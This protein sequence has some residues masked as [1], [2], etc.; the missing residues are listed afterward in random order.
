M[1]GCQFHCPGCFNSEAWD[2]KAGKPF[3]KKAYL[4][5]KEYLS[6]PNIS[7][8]SILGGDPL[9][10][11]DNGIMNLVMLCSYVHEIG[12]TVWIWSGFTW[13]EIFKEDTNNTRAMRAMLIGNCDVWVDG[14]FDESKKDLRLKWR[15][16][17]NQ[18]VIDVKKS[19]KEKKIVL[20]EE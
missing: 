6:D 10:Q 11:D 12:K 5:I 15:G 3:G 2:Y 14:L 7:G 18:R 1:S 8:L 4:R 13:E 20:Y 17:S 16:S 9:W 19:L